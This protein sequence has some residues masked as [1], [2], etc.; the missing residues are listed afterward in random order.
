MNTNNGNPL[1]NRGRNA[2]ERIEARALLAPPVDVYENQD[3]ILVVAD[4]PG[5]RADS[6]TVRLDK[7]QLVISARREKDP[8]GHP[9]AGG[10]GAGDYQRT[11]VVPRGVDSTRIDAELAGGVLRVHLPKS[12]ALKPRVIE[13]RSS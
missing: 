8:E 12:A 9:L 2:A 13:V 5:A 1:V 10:G 6:V 11:F 3:E 4:V 7:D